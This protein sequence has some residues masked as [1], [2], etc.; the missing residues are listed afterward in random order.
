MLET[1]TDADLHAPAFRWLTAREITVAGV[2]MKALR[3]SYV[4]ELGWEAHMP[5]ESMGEVRALVAAGEP[6]GMVHFGS[7][8]ERD[9]IE[10]GYKAWNGAHDRDHPDRGPHRTLRR[11]RRRLLGKEATVARR[12]Q[13]DPLSWCSS[14]ARSRTASPT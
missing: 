14:T 9:A 1:L 4:G 11:L 8:D 13:A 12:D 5:I 7:C 3:V 10:K 6:H 2:A